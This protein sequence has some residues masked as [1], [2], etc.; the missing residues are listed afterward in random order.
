MNTSL[1]P[2][3][4][5]VPIVT[6][7][8][9]EGC[10]DWPAYERVLEHVVTG[11][12]DAVFVLGTTGEGT[13]LSHEE[14][15][16]LV[17][18]TC[19]QVRKRCHVYVG[20][21][22]TSLGESLHLSEVSRTCGADAVVIVPSPYF[23]AGVREQIAFFT[24]FTE[25]A[26]LP[27]ILYNI[28][29]MTKTALAPEAFEA[30]LDDPRIVGLKDSSGNQVYFRRLQHVARRR[31]GFAMLIGSEELL[32]E[33]VLTGAAGGVVGG[34]NVC[35]QLY[36]LLFEAATRRDLTEVSRL[37][38]R[39][40][41]LS[42]RLYAYGNG[43]YIIAGIKAMLREKG[44]CGLHVLLPLLPAESRL[45]EVARELVHEESGFMP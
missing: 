17:K 15:R 34:A 36:K 44:L 22:D 37:Q 45:I 24:Q 19:G 30:L 42:C 13:S 20:V 1:S 32:A 29:Q 41:D 38:T 43:G 10:I 7:F 11:G 16:A 40:M 4:V 18:Q 28:P 8:T 12:V 23:P 21:M 14:K 35:P 5:I 2:R 31:A 33:S 27:V 26:G 6:P 25:R 3:G 39:V 9:D